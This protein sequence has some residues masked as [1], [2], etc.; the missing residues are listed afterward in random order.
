M[1]LELFSYCRHL[2]VGLAA[3]ELCFDTETPTP[4]LGPI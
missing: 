3:E 1:Q 4:G 2:A